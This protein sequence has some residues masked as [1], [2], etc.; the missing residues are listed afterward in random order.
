MDFAKITSYI[1]ERIKGKSRKGEIMFIGTFLM[2]IAGIA[3]GLCIA[4]AT[5]KSEGMTDFEEILQF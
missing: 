5:I 3:L 4:A 2:V 1:M